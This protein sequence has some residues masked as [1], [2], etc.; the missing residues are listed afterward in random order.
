MAD[1]FTNGPMVVWQL[2]KCESPVVAGYGLGM[3]CG[4]LGPTVGWSWMIY[5]DG[6]IICQVYDVILFYTIIIIIITHDNHVISIIF[7]RICIIL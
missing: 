3:T 7:V 6:I 1:H 5:A 4:T 2:P